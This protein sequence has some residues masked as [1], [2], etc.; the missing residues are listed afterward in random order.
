MERARYLELLELE[1]T[2]LRR[3]AA[4]DLTADVPPCPGWTVT[5]VVE[6]IAQV[7][8]HKIACV[9]LGGAPP[10][11]WPP[12]WP[13][14]REPLRWF[15]DAQHRLINLL[16]N[17]DPA[18]PSWTWWPED[19][20]AGFWIRRMAQESAIHRADVESARGDITPVDAEL[21]VDGVDEVLT[22]MLAGDWSE[23]P[24]P[25]PPCTV[26][27]RVGDRTWQVGMSPEEVAVGE[28]T[29]TAA[30]EVTS[31][32]SDLLLWLW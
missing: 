25:G 31:N 10:D 7:Y 20:S 29:G 8:E 11:P 19:Q 18:A 14:D 32:P 21:A 1:G 9:T 4:R 26:D 6:H 3:A 16:T 30:A 22:R 17:I 2:R 28:A 5:D 12:S 23:E 13:A 24:Q 15:E 27:V